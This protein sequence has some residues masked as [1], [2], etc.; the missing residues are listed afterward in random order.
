MPVDV[1]VYDGA[2]AEEIQAFCPEAQAQGTMFVIPT[3]QGPAE[4]YVGDVLMKSIGTGSYSRLD[5]DVFF[6]LYELQ[7]M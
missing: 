2:N 1:V 4:L 7:P 5:A 3:E 6:G